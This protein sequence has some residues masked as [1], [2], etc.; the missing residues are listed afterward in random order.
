MTA[1][2]ALL[3]ALHTPYAGMGD[4]KNCSFHLVPCFMMAKKVQAVAK[5]HSTAVLMQQ[6]IGPTWGQS[7]LQG[8]CT[9]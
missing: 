7:V 6:Q 5:L 9:L 1:G 4:V 8:N 2:F 3:A